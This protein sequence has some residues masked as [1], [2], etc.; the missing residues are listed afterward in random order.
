MGFGIILITLTWL[1]TAEAASKLGTAFE[2]F[3]AGRSEMECFGQIDLPGV[4]L[5]EENPVLLDI[6]RGGDPRSARKAASIILAV[7][8][9]R[10]GD[11][12][13]KNDAGALLPALIAHYYDPDPEQPPT[14]TAPTDSWRHAIMYVLIQSNAVPPP[15][16]LDAIRA[17][18]NRRGDAF[19]LTG[20]LAAT[21]LTHLRPIPKGAVEAILARMDE[22]E[23]S[24]IEMISVLGA[25]RVDDPRVIQRIAI[26]LESHSVGEALPA[27]APVDG[28]GGVRN[29]NALH[30]AAA[31]ALGQIGA[32]AKVALPALRALATA[33]DPSVDEGAR[34]AARQAIRLIGSER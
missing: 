17:D 10:A 4:D 26:A 5:A 20:T 33:A 29:T 21:T 18:L 2:Q 31:Q 14:V 34:Q 23:Q 9:M 6:L 15:E 25:N 28:A 8:M 16:L 11:G 30:L 3:K 32:P 1:A 22:S 13:A 24:R 27:G 12:K 7:L 19:H